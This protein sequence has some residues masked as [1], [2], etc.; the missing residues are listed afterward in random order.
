VLGL[1][2]VLGLFGRCASP[3]P[4]ARTLEGL[5]SMLGQAAGGVVNPKDIVWE[6]SPGFLSETFVSR[7]VLFLAA[8][9][10]GQPRDLYRARVRVTFE[11]QPISVRQ[12]RNVTETPL[13]DDVAL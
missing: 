7:P 5:A 2:A 4:P 8:A 10:A 3:G 11:G 9:K 12:L 13:G 6:P 1:A